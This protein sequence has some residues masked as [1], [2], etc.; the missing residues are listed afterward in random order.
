MAN[1]KYCGAETQLYSLGEPICIKCADQLEQK[2]TP[3]AETK[4]DLSLKKTA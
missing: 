1:C 2:K 4:P 3:I